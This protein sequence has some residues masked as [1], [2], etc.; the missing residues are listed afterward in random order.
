M[1][2]YILCNSPLGSDYSGEGEYHLA[3]ET[4]IYYKRYC[5]SRGFANSDLTR[6]VEDLLK[7]YGITEVYSNGMLVWVDGKMTKDAEAD[8][9][10][11]NYEYERVNSDAL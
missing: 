11:A 4:A 2:A 3:T 5:S 9:R 1:K 10:S 7:G 6:A 8:F